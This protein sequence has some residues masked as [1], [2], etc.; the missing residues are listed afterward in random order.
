[1]DLSW[2]KKFTAS[3]IDLSMGEG[4]ETLP[5]DHLPT[6]PPSFAMRPSFQVPLL[7]QRTHAPIDWLLNVTNDAWYGD[8]FGPYQHL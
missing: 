4:P 1:M 5:I 6:F 2:M 7:A 8:S 3:A